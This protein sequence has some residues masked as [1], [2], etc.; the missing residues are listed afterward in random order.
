M[1]L[2][3][4]GTAYPESMRSAGQPA[5]EFLF[6]HA[7]LEC[8]IAIDKDDRDLIVI[9]TSEFG[10]AVNVNFAPME[11]A[12]LMKFDEAL[13][14]DFAEMTTLARIDDNLARLHMSGSVAGS[15]RYSKARRA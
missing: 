15:K 7:V 1:V 14:D 10:I 8:L 11:A 12:S 3:P 9:L 6:V 4:G 13:L 5:E 2:F